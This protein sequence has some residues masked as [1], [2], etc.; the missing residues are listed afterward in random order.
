[1][2]FKIITAKNTAPLQDHGFFGP[3]SI[4]WRVWS[5]PT[6]FALGFIRSVTIEELD[7]HLIAAVVDSGGV[8]GRTRTRYDRTLHYFALVKFGDSA[9]ATRAANVLVKVHSKAVGDD[10]VSGRRYDA[11]DPDSQLWIHIT[12]WHSIL[13]CYEKF[14]PGKLT[15]DEENQYWAECAV[16]AELQ[17]ILLDDV[18]RTREQVRAYF[19]S[20]RLKVAGSEQAQQMMD[21][22]LNGVRYVV[23]D[24]P[25]GILKPVTLA[26]SR[27]HRIAVIATLPRYQR[28]LAGIRQSRLLD[29]AIVPPMKLMYRL[30]A[31]RPA[32]PLL[33]TLLQFISPSTVPVV[34]PYFLGI[35]PE[36]PRTYT[37]AEAR[38]RLEILPPR[39]EY[40]RFRKLVDRRRAAGAQTE[41][42]LGVGPDVAE[43]VELIGPTAA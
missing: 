12:A 43:S 38:E 8:Y 26:L 11:N 4:T 22:L 2:G 24:S 10:P 39:E 1:M 6:S 14:G 20:W 13:Y 41:V 21:F 42:E 18:P 32:R 5:Y 27:L 23:P 15:D 40:A 31:S 29:A 3:D 28:N 16:A 36:D 25:L 17:T 9:T 37:P 35:D 34:A 30:L 7:P 33:P 19:D